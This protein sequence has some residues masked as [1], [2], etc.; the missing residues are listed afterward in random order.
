MYN[1]Y[2]L[3]A[4]NNTP[5][6]VN[7]S[8]VTLD[9]NETLTNNTFYSLFSAYYR[10]STIENE[11]ALGAHINSI[12]YLIAI[13]PEDPSFD[14]SNEKSLTVTEMD[15]LNFLICTTKDREVFLPVFT[16]SRELT[17]W[18]H[19]PVYT[20]RVPAVWLWQFVLK[21]GNFNGIVFNPGSIGWDINL[22]HIQSLLDDI[23]SIS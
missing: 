23:Q 8:S 21:Q 4:S 6:K 15:D 5:T 17:R 11:D 7:A 18:Y 16:D 22:E 9:V 20:I 2:T 13:L 14:C 3:N 19:E 12:D 10:H 1:F